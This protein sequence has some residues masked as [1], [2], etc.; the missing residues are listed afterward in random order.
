MRSTAGQALALV[1]RAASG[2]L[3]AYLASVLLASAVPVVMAWLTKLILDGL[4]TGGVLLPPA[5]GLAAVEIG[6]AHV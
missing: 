5:A 3:L 4:V 2:T 1:W 6:R